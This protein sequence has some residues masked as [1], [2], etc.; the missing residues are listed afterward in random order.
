MNFKM[1]QE[2]LNE[3]LNYLVQKPYREVFSL[4]EH[5]KQASPVE[6]NVEKL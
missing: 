4:I 3:I 2:H 6:E 5:L 1:P